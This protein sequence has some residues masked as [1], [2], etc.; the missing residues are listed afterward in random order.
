MI[1]LFF[2]FI[3]LPVLLFY[4][5]RAL[6]RSVVES[7]AQSVADQVSWKYFSLSMKNLR[8]AVVA[9]AQRRGRK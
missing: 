2:R 9:D 6:L 7:I 1:R 3:V 5:A 8:D 4:L